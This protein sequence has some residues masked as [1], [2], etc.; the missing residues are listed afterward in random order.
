VHHAPGTAPT[1]APTTLGTI[2]KV[3]ETLTTRD[4][5][6]TSRDGRALNHVELVYRPGE[7]DLAARVFALLGCRPHDTGRTYLTSFVEPAEGDFANNAVYASEVTP[8]QWRLECALADALADGGPVADAAHGYLDRFHEEPQ[9]STHFGIRVPDRERFDAVIAALRDA[10]DHDPE[11]A[12]RVRVSA[13]FAPGDPGSLT[14]TMIQAFVHTD[15]VAAGL[16]VLG[17]HFE[18]QYQFP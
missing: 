7:R 9:R 6:L 14:D 17:Q 1:R 8:E 13:V 3:T 16:L 10:A 11:L 2:A 4:P 18:L 12:G 15:V 5:N